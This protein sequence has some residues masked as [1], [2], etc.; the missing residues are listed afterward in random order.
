MKI[1]K[2]YLRPDGRK[3]V[4]ITN[5][6]GSKTTRSYPRYLL[7]EKLGRALL[8]EETVDHIDGD[9]TNDSL[10]NLRVLTRAENASWAWKTGN[11]KPVP[12][13]E[14]NKLMHKERIKGTKNPLAKFT[15]EQ[16]QNIR[17]KVK[18][19]GLTND[20]CVEYGVSKKTIYNI[21]KGNSY[22]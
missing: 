21:L 17:N 4:I 7:E 9:H 5:D 2:P 8:P 12:M 6:D 15:L 16:I 13:K 18:Y 19:R 22:V 11:C 14:E 1:S 3:H 20:L 10:D